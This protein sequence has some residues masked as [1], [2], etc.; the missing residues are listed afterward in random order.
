YNIMPD[1][2]EALTWIA[3]GAAT[4]GRLLI[5]NVPFNTME[6]PLIHLREAGLSLFSNSDS[7]VVSPECLDIHGIQPFELACGTHPGVISDMQSFFVFL[8]LFA[9]GRSI[10]F[11][12]RYPERI[13]YAQELSKF[14]TGN[15]DST[16]GRI[17]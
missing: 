3:L 14:Y 2:I 7:I 12:Y 15:I 6:V 16:P 17:V 10:I 5:K 11:D 1:R 4:G 13:A 9:T 8:S